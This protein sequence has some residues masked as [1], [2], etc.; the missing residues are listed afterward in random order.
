MLDITRLKDAIVSNAKDIIDPDFSVAEDPQAAEDD[1][2]ETWEE[3]G[4]VISKSVIEEIQ[5]NAAV[6]SG[7]EVQDDQDDV[8]GSTSEDGTVT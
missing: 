2:N 3:I 8:V 7:I 6:P 1:F 5:D 4:E